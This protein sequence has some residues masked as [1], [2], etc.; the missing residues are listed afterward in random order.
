MIDA[1]G[2]RT[3]H[4]GVQGGAEGEHIAGRSGV[5]A[6]R[7]L[8]GE[9]CGGSGDDAVVGFLHVALGSRDAEIADLDD[10][11]IL[12]AVG[13]QNVARLDVAMHDSG[14][15]CFGQGVGDLR[16]DLSDFERW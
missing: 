9:V 8:G 3:F 12:A 5:L 1:E 16:T 15:V 6:A 14:V 2:R 4:C 13:D 10:A 7:D 11:Q